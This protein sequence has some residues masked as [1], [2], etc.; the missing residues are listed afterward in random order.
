MQTYRSLEQREIVRVGLSFLGRVLI[1][2]MPTLFLLMCGLRFPGMTNLMLWMGTGFNGLVLVLCLVNRR[3]WDQPLGAS[4]IMLYLIGLAWL[5]V[6]EPVPDWFTHFAKAVLLVT[7]LV[8]FGYQT[9]YE[10]GAP[11]L[12][13]A[14][15]LAQRLADRKEWPADL[16]ACR[17][18]PEV[19][20]LRAALNLDAGPALVLLQHPRPEV[21][22]AALGALEFRK[23]WGPGEAELV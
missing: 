22:V 17:T 15:V 16:S 1:L 14:N 5:W 12:R 11:A 20:A 2:A 13:H 18:L 9:L 3:R 8:V 10:S 6:A 19:K 21:R 7:P 4:V 23:D